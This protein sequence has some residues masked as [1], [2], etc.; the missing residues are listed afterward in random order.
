MYRKE[1]K[2]ISLNEKAFL[3]FM[4]RRRATDVCAAMNNTNYSQIERA[5]QTR[6]RRDKKKRK[7]YTAELIAF[8]PGRRTSLKREIH[9]TIHSL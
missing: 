4:L 3:R 8:V 6:Y 9:E 7:Q 5:A 2:N 1:S